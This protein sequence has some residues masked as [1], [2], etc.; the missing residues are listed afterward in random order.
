MDVCVF[1]YKYVCGVYLYTIAVVCDELLVLCICVYVY[2]CICMCV[3][4]FVCAP[5]LESASFEGLADGD[6][7]AIA[8]ISWARL[9][10]NF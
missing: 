6:V 5:E 2:M 3:C 9:V 10:P 4:V 1:A 8:N 7:C